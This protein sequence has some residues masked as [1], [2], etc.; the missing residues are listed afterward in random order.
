[1][2]GVFAPM[3]DDGG[4]EPRSTMTLIEEGA[5]VIEGTRIVWLGKAGDLPARWRSSACVDLKGRCV[6]PGLIDCHT[7]LVYAGERAHEWQRRLEGESYASIAT[8]GGGIA[9][10]VKATRAASQDELVRLAVARLHNW[11]AEGVTT[12]EI[13][14]GYGLAIESE[15]K[16]LRAARQ[17]GQMVPLRVMTTFLG[18]HAVPL[19]YKDCPS[20]YLGVVINEML[21]AIAREHLADAVDIFV[22]HLAFDVA[23]G[24]RLFEAA[25]AFG[26]KVKVHADQLSDS[27]GARLA[28]DY[29]ALSADHLEYTP[30][31]SVEA[32][33][34]S[35]VV[36]VLLPAAFYSMQEKQL[37]PIDA[38]RTSRV[39][40]ALATDHNPGTSPCSSLLMVLNLACN[41]FRLTPAEALL[42][43][44]RHAAR[45]LGIEQQTGSLAIGLDADIAIWDVGHVR[46]L[47]Y[48]FGQRPLAAS[49]AKGR[50]VKRLESSYSSELVR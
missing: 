41:L 50:W 20:E 37:P 30:K 35:G 14:S 40:M 17:L 43:V 36:A 33:A 27:G 48:G 5:I 31:A 19:E 26:L 7:H 44:T 8:S 15:L 1:M 34:K 10:S 46:E 25:K 32:M 29:A 38:F 16:M 28:A 13:K 49:L 42:G 47:C 21:P 12:V 22:E 23:D 39:A 2:N 4:A 24:R 3:T 6:T 11:L 45:A 9:S 18:A